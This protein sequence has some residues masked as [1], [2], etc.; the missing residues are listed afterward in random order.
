MLKKHYL[1][2]GGALAGMA[3][4]GALLLSRS[5]SVSADAPP[6]SQSQSFF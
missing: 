3:L 6:D 1:V 2:M 5:A 4:L